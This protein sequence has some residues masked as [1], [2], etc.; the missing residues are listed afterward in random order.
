M[1]LRSVA[2]KTGL[3]STA[4]FDPCDVGVLSLTWL[5]MYEF[6]RHSAKL[7]KD[8]GGWKTAGISGIRPQNQHA[9]SDEA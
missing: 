2:L 7:V 6:I 5:H 9:L 3:V 4:S 1:S 8:S